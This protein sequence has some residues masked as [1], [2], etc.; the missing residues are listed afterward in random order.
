MAK[1]ELREAK[2]AEDGVRVCV[3]QDAHDGSW[4]AAKESDT[5]NGGTPLGAFCSQE[6]ARKWADMEHP[7]GSWKPE[8]GVTIKTGGGTD[9]G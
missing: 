9:A 2:S 5:K 4:F 3:Y 1:F 7:G 8:S 6:A